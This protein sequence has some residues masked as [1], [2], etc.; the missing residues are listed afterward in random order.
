MRRIILLLFVL[1]NTV[2][3]YGQVLNDEEQKMYDLI[4]EYRKEKGLPSIPLSPSLTFVAQTHAMDV[5]MNNPCIDSCSGHSWSDKGKWTPCCYTLDHAQAQCMWNKPRELTSYQA[6]GYEI[7][8]RY[9][10]KEVKTRIMTAEDALANW[11]SS[12]GH[13]SVIINEGQW[14]IIDWKA[15]GIGI[16]KGYACVWFGGLEDN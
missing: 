9:K 15:I 5:L 4:M 2:I 14:A 16:Y 8:T 11:K 7:V 12:P 3:S 10:T 6:D 1:M 13:N